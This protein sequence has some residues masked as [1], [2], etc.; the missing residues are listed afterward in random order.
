MPE[1]RHHLRRNI[2]TAGVV[3]YLILPFGHSPTTR[4][5]DHDIELIESY[6]YDRLIR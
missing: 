1:S 5:V 2:E 4:R 3:E 6:V